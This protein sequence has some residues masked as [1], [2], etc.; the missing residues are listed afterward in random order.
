MVLMTMMNANDYWRIA[1]FS[2]EYGLKM[3]SRFEHRPIGRRM[4]L[5]PCGIP[6]GFEG[7][8]I[9]SWVRR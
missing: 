2:V 6:V 9:G 7:D 1:L 8:G 4:V 5:G 3:K